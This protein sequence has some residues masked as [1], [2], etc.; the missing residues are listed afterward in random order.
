MNPKT[1]IVLLLLLVALAGGIVL[2]R[3]M[4]SDPEETGDLSGEMTLYDPQPRGIVELRIQSPAGQDLRF[5]LQDGEQW[6][7]VEPF[8]MD[9]RD[10]EVEKL[11]KLLTL[12]RPVRK[13][14][15]SLPGALADTMTGLDQPRWTLTATNRDGQSYVLHVGRQAAAIGT[16]ET[17]TYVRTNQ[18]EMT[19]VLAQDLAALLS[20]P[21]EAYRDKQVW[22]LDREAVTHVQLEGR[23]VFAL[24]HG[25]DGWRFSQPHSAPADAKAVKAYLDTL[26]ALQEKELIDPSPTDPARYGL[27]RPLLR[28]VLSVQSEADAPSTQPATQPDTQPAPPT[29]TY[30]LLVA[31]RG[32]ELLAATQGPDG[33]GAVFSLPADK[34]D[35]LQPSA[36]SLRDPALL[37]VQPL[38]V[39][40]IVLHHDGRDLRIERKNGWMLTQPWELPAETQVVDDYLT[41][42]T[43]LQAS[44]WL[45]AT[46]GQADISAPRLRVSLEILGKNQTRTLRVGGQSPTGRMTFVQGDDSSTPAAIPTDKAE[47][48]FRSAADFAGRTLLTIP[49]EEAI[50]AVELRSPKSTVQ[51]RKQDDIWQMTAPQET[52]ANQDAIEALLGRLRQL[53]AESIAAVDESPEAYSGE[54]TITITLS[55]SAEM[56]EDAPAGEEVQYTLAVSK[57][58]DAVYV[59]RPGQT[60]LRVGKVSPELWHAVH[61]EWRDPLVWDLA[62]ETITAVTLDDGRTPFTLQ[63][64]DDAWSVD[65]DPVLPIDAETVNTYCKDVGTL[66]AESFVTHTTDDLETFGLD[67]P[68]LTLRLRL[69]DG[70]ERTLRISANA[71]DGH[72]GRYASASETLGVF[73]VSADTLNR[74][75][76]DLKHFSA[77]E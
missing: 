17:E 54:E 41:T 63:R 13:F 26:L 73:V 35:A 6:G 4:H 70:T 36:D 39:G 60:P 64:K 16:S 11:V 3:L 21:A 14:D 43:E 74:I 49:A 55:G 44:D 38:Q 56:T 76:R 61:A 7:L 67:K 50:A 48:L 68:A 22:R 75:H 65:L 77:A 57:Q 30:A 29:E 23:D 34:L 53:R 46:L 9:V 12:A 18:N 47:A 62:P 15:P 71:P 2:T 66:R 10:A 20:R 33:L 1:T 40:A 27:D 25:D 58:D 19:Y 42:L 52:P 59:W 5:R 28:V 32:Q 8:A 72:S 24:T 51:L 45:D 69:E 31:R 37:D